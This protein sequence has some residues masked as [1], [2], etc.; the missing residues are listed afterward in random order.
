MDGGQQADVNGVEGDFAVEVLGEHVAHERLGLMID[1]EVE[2]QHG[3]EDQG[4]SEEPPKSV[5]TN[6]H[7]R[8]MRDLG[9]WSSFGE[10]GAATG[11]IRS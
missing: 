5:P 9:N 3:A 4:R 10:P 1:I 11:R 6:G 7:N 2:E 8:W